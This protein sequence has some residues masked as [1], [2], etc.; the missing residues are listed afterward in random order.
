MSKAVSNASSLLDNVSLEASNN[1]EF[2]ATSSAS[3]F[4]LNENG[5][6]AEIENDDDDLMD[7]EMPPSEQN[8]MFSSRTYVKKVV[9]LCYIIDLT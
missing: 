1:F 2:V 5:D 8:A 7:E 4:K 6:Y 9:C 3:K